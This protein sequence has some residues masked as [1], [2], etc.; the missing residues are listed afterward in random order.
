MAGDPASLGKDLTPL[1]GE[2]AASKNGK[3]PAYEG[4]G[5]Q[6][7]GYVYGKPRGDYFKYKDDKPLFVIDAS[8]VDQY[9]ESLAPGQIQLI[10]QLKGFTLPVYPSRRTCV[11]PDVV[12]EN[13][14]KNASQAKI[15]A[16]G[17]SLDGAVLPG[18][19]FPMPSKGIEAVWNHLTRYMGVAEEFPA[20]RTW[21]SPKAGTDRGV[22]IVYNLWQM[23]PNS[24]KGENKP[25]GGSLFQGLYFGY[26][27]PSSLSG[28]AAIQRFYFDKP[29]EAYYYFTGQRRVRRLPTYD[30]DA[31]QIGY[32][33]L[34]NVDQTTILYG[35]PDRF[36]W[37]VVGKKEMYVPYNA[38]GMYDFSKKMQDTLLEPNVFKPEL[39]RYELHRVWVIEGTVKS[40]IRHANPKRTLYLDEDSWVAVGGEDFDAQGKVW[41]W[42]ESTPIPAWELGGACVIPQTIMYDLTNLRL[43]ADSLNFSSGKDF[44]FYPAAAGSAPQLKE[45]FYTSE[46]LQRISDR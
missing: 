17:W 22:E 29:T 20:A 32:E 30:Y 34:Y 36:D 46:S 37:K 25:G 7:P 21:I 11:A 19:P 3:V 39:R 26:I 4:A 23:Q 15:G 41:K 12:Q 18:V 16:D 10:K 13:T 31:P 44:K 5:A 1:G 8:N 2:M 6:L 40:G 28:Q 43:M 9:A 45:N 38:F 24:V 35:A 33:N 42:K 14:K 27:E